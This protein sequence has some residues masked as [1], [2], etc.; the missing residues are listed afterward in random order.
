MAYADETGFYINKQRVWLQTVSTPEPSYFEPHQ[1]RGVKATDAIDILL[2]YKGIFV[3]DAWATYFKYNQVN[4][5]LRNV[6]HLRD[7]NGVIENNDQQWALLMKSAPVSAEQLVVEAYL[8][9]Y[10]E[11][12]P[13]VTRRIE[14]MYAAIIEI[15]IS[16]NPWEILPPHLKRRGRYKKSKARNLVERFEHDQDAILRSV[17]DVKVP[18]DNNL[19]ERNIQMMK[20][21]QNISGCFRSCAGARQFCQLRSYAS[22]LRK[23]GLNVWQALGVLFEG[24]LLMS[25][26]IPVW[27][28]QLILLE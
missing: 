2:K 9:G 27:L 10:D 13:E 11:L 6:H 17:H 14:Q 24:N 15:G 25:V 22:A 23:Q 16:K 7:L 19:A 28:Q 20:V 26:T 5:A 1:N 4:H 3:H 18:F 21:Q 8:A 12:T